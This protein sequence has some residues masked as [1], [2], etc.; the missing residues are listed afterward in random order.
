M[1]CR[2]TDPSAHPQKA[3]PS[4]NRVFGV[5]R[6]LPRRGT[7]TGG[8][9]SVPGWGTRA[10]VD[11][12][13]VEELMAGAEEQRV[14]GASGD[15]TA[16][17]GG[18]EEGRPAWSQAGLWRREPSGTGTAGSGDVASVGGLKGRGHV[19]KTATQRDGQRPTLGSAGSAAA[20]WR[21]GLAARS[22]PPAEPGRLYRH[23]AASH[24]LHASP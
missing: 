1:S 8:R 13:H 18:L 24:V 5:P 16:P 17:A 10:L 7:W 23:R 20:S 12:W 14:P 4:P 21:M 22:V 3:T 2:G 15:E 11:M 6:S 9:K 19:R